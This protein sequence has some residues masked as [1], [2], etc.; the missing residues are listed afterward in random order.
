VIHPQVAARPIEDAELL[1]LADAGE[2]AVLNA[3]GAL[4][5]QQL[6]AGATIGELTRTLA[7]H[8]GL[9]EDRAQADVGALLHA[10]TELGALEGEG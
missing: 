8:Y 9:D 3:A 4:V 7:A 10:L 2:V 1:L 6:E 5:W